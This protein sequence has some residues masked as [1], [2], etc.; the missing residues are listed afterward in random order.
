MI[1]PKTLRGE[2]KATKSQLRGE[3][4]QVRFVGQQMSNLCFNL[5][6][7]KTIEKSVRESMK[8]LYQKWDAIK[9]AEKT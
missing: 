2:R 9:R 4:C 8:D 5:S 1:D 7:N 3:L 6:Q